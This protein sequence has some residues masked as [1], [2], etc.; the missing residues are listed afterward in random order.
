MGREGCYG[1]YSALGCNKKEVS[2]DNGICLEEIKYYE[3]ISDRLRNILL[4]Q[5]SLDFQ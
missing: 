4:F 5:S 2:Q 1:V 3:Y